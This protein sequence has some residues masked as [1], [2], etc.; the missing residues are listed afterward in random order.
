[1]HYMHKVPLYLYDLVVP[2]SNKGYIHTYTRP[3]PIWAS[4]HPSMQSEDQAC[5]TPR[6]KVHRSQPPKLIYRMLESE[7]NKRKKKLS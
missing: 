1:M 4:C 6:I 7:N 5:S 2:N 3:L